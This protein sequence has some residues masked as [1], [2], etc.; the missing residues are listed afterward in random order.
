MVLPVL[1]AAIVG[2]SRHAAHAGP[3]AR[4][5][6]TGALSDQSAPQELELGPMFAVGERA[7]PF[8]GELEYAYMSFSDPDVSA[9]GIH[10][11]G[12]TLR[13]DLIRNTGG[14]C[15]RYLACTRATTLY[16]EVGAAERLG[17]WRLD[18]HTNSLANQREAHVGLGLEL[19]NHLSPLRYGWQLGL[20]LAFAPHEQIAGVSCRGTGCPT[21]HGGTDR[22]VLVEWTFVIGK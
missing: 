10:R 15:F 4:F 2:A 9:N 21:T 5:G 22:A 19:D 16:G 7:G 12:V 17:Y 13:A 1:L 6:L 8:V 14:P 11:L 3:T 20:R 18:S